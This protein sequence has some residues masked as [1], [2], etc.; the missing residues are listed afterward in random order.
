[1]EI[2]GSDFHHMDNKDFEISKP[3]IINSHV[4]IGDKA[5]IRLGVTIG[6]G[7]VI[8]RGAFVTRSVV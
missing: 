4:W 8:A 1:M 5:T 7:S 6:S 3:I 2:I